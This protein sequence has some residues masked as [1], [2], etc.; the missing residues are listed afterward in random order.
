MSE[1]NE[2][3][4]IVSELNALRLKTFEV[5][6]SS[7]GELRDHYNRVVSKL[8]DY[9]HKTDSR[10]ILEKLKEMPEWRESLG[11]CFFDGVAGLLN[12]LMQ[13]GLTV[14]DLVEDELKESLLAIRGICDSII[15]VLTS[16]GL[17]EMYYN[18]E[19]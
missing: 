17:E 5:R 12:I 13:G 4:A 1:D 18:K 14:P 10:F 16:P 15:A 8:E 6:Q 19:N 7:Y 3:R 11:P 2:R 9:A